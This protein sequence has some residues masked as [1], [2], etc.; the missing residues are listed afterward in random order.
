MK[1]TE[2]ERTDCNF[3]PFTPEIHNDD[4]SHSFYISAPTYTHPPETERVT[5]KSQ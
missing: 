4:H 3:V 5:V 2:S 1:I